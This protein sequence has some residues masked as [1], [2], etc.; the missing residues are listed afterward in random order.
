MN[1]DNLKRFAMHC[2]FG[3]IAAAL[4]AVV[5]GIGQLHLNP[6]EQAIVVALATSGASFFRKA[7]DE[8]A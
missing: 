8:N 4:L 3:G 2:A 1:M 7:A 6:T 5:A